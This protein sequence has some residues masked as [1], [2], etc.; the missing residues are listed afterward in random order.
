MFKRLVAVLFFSTVFI[1]TSQ[2]FAKAPLEF[3]AG[4][5]VLEEMKW[6]GNDLELSFGDS[7]EYSVDLVMSDS[8][9]VLRFLKPFYRTGVEPNLRGPNGIRAILT[10][11]GS[12][13]GDANLLTVR[14]NNRIGYSTLWRPH[15]KRLIVHTFDWN[16]LSFAESQYHHGLLALEQN[17]PDLAIEY[18]NAAR[19]ADNGPIARRA[20]SVLAMLYERQGK[21]SLAKTYLTH[22]SDPDDH[23]VLAAIARRA[24]DSA[25]AKRAESAMSNALADGPRPD[26]SSP[27]DAPDLGGD[28]TTEESGTNTPSDFLKDWRGIALIA[29]AALLIL[30]LATWFM[31]RGNG[32]RT[33]ET[34]AS[35]QAKVEARNAEAGEPVAETVAEPLSERVAEP[36]PEPTSARTIVPPPVAPIDERQETPPTKPEATTTERTRLSAQAEQLRRRVEGADKETAAEVAREAAAKE[37]PATTVSASA[38]EATPASPAGESTISQ[39]RRL[40]VSRD[41]VELRDRL[42][43]IRGEE[44]EKRG[45]SREN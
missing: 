30:L 28:S 10:K 4:S 2:T 11:E 44:Q 43:A 17:L 8:G 3:P 12:V 6:I 41:Y 27:N 37:A 39:A 42:A 25:A 33:V 14:G 24:G 16:K 5:L 18:L 35:R 1:S 15:S 29:G 9:L 19:A 26:A 13:V 34:S 31:R 21:D 36:A 7:V 22:P 40:N 38:E 32:P 20:E 45:R 23:G